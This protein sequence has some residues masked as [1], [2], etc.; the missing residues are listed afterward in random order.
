MQ[1]SNTILNQ[2]ISPSLYEIGHITKDIIGF[3][4]KVIVYA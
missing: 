2:C 4:F 3:K 1:I